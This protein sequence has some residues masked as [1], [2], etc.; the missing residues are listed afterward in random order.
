MP[1]LPEVETTCRMLEPRLRGRSIAGVRV[2]E[3][4]L[5]QTV[6]A[7]ALGRLRGARVEGVSRR[8]KYVLI[9]LNGD[10]LLVV[11]LGMTGHLTVVDPSDERRDHEHVRFALDDGME[12]RFRDPRR[13]GLITTARGAELPDHPLFARLGV[14][15]LSDAFD[16]AY[17][18]ALGKSSR[19]AVKAFI[20]DGQVVVGVGNIYATESLFLAGVRPGRAA[21]RL[22]RDEWDRLAEAIKSTLAAAI[23]QCGTTVNSY[24]DPY[25]EPGAFQNSLKAY[26]RTGA[27]CRACGDAIRRRVIGQRSSFYCP[28]CQR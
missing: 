13:F 1:E 22:T 2:H 8:A 9:R 28:T 7:R 10:R 12:L 15:P 17:L 19:R 25:G 21:R 4:R 26:G 6:D 18:R 14:E 23:R 5:R 20:M 24:L 3:S 16:G 27:P 11:H